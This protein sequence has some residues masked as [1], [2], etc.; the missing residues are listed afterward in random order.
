V[1]APEWEPPAPPV[2]GYNFKLHKDKRGVQLWK[3][4]TIHDSNGR[5]WRNL[6][7]NY[8]VWAKGNFEVAAFQDLTRNG[9]RDP[10]RGHDPRVCRQGGGW[11]RGLLS[12]RKQLALISSGAGPDSM[13][14]LGSVARSVQAKTALLSE[15]NGALMVDVSNEDSTTAASWLSINLRQRTTK[16]SQARPNRLR[17]RGLEAPWPRSYRSPSPRLVPQPRS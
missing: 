2:L 6:D 3:L 8:S 14:S 15:S 17:L 13:R 12:S 16:R 9:R 1:L 4:T 7:I 10:R 11:S 5:I